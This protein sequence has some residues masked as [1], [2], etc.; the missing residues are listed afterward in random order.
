[1]QQLN[2]VALKT[3]EILK[4]K[5]MSKQAQCKYCQWNANASKKNSSWAFFPCLSTF[6]HVVRRKNVFRCRK[7]CARKKTL[8][9]F[10]LTFWKI[11]LQLW[12][13]LKM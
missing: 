3:G 10:P 4:K 5:E 11:N 12:S 1:M 6:E 7:T 13:Q 8:H 9:I 2:V